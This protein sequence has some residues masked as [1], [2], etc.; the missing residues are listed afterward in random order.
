[1]YS[2]QKFILLCFAYGTGRKY[3]G[4]GSNKPDAPK[5]R[6]KAIYLGKFVDTNHAGD[7][8]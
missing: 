6:G 4:G 3:E 2:I 1:M 5:T 7:K 8:L